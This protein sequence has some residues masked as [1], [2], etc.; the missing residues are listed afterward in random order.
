MRK[1]SRYKKGDRYGKLV[2][3]SKSRP[4]GRGIGGLWYA[5]CDCG[6]TI[7]V[8]VLQVWHG[9]VSTCGRC[10]EGLGIQTT[11]SVQTQ[12]ISAGHLA[13]FTKLVKERPDAQL[14]SHKYNQIIRLRCV[15]CNSQPVHAEWSDIAGT[16]LAPICKLCSS[17][18]SGRSLSKWL[19]HCLRVATSLQQ[20]QAQLDS[21]G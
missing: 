12:R 9:R 16:P 4:G 20:R 8:V 11:H 14:T 21:Q 15:G 19:A 7:E 13:Q 18:L 5:V 1:Y 3:L 6:N 10:G 17:W 2:L